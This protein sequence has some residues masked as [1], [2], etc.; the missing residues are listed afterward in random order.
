MMRDVLTIAIEGGINYWCHVKK[1]DYDNIYAEIL[2]IVDESEHH[3]KFRANRSLRDVEP[4][5][6]LILKD[7]IGGQ[8]V[9]L[10]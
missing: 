1:V 5:V 6:N 9:D 2:E 7:L 3:R 10:P 4:D 8:V